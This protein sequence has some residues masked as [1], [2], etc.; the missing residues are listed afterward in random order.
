M[1]GIGNNARLVQTVAGVEMGKTYDLTFSIAD[2][3]PT[4]ADDGVRVSWG[5][6]VVYEGLPGQAW[7]TITRHVVGGGGDG[8]NKLMFQ[9]TET[10]T[11]WYGAALDDVSLCKTIEAPFL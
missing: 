8:S 4:T 10:N 1:D 9:G 5:G 11:N 3:D 6:Q 2:Q 7:Q